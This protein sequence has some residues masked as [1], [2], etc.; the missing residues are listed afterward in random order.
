MKTSDAA[1]RA[2]LHGSREAVF[3][4]LVTL[5]TKAG[6]TVR[7]AA[8]G[9]DVVYGGNTYT[10][11][12]TGTAPLV[13]PMRIREAV[14]LE[15]STLELNLD[16]GTTAQIGGVALQNAALNGVLDDARVTVHRAYM[17][18]PGGAVVG[19]IH[20]F[21]GVVSDC[22]VDSYSVRLRVQSDLYKLEEPLPRH[23]IR[24]KCSWDW[25]GPGCGL[26][27]S[28]WQETHT[29]QFAGAGSANFATTAPTVIIPFRRGGWIEVTSG[30]N[31]GLR[32]EVSDRGYEWAGG[33][34]YTGYFT[35]VVALP[36][37]LAI[38][39]TY[40]FFPGCDK[41]IATCRDEFS[42]LNR[43]RGFDFVPSPEQ[44]TR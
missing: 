39:D 23:L 22:E 25:A 1:L 16:C 8:G 34:D 13:Q 15:V 32:R 17:A 27:A 6:T 33:T 10:G 44:V 30:A 4:N 43:R 36:S 42:N 14:G 12:G 40:K 19:V 7:W 20:R 5:V 31:N 28:A 24:E 37:P 2:L 41:T 11:S 21:A 29:Q 38:G 26:T 35:L 9:R 3:T 18:T